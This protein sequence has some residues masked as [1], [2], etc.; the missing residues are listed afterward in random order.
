[1]KLIQKVLVKLRSDVEFNGVVTCCYCLDIPVDVF[2]ALHA[3][4]VVDKHHREQVNEDSYASNRK[5]LH[6]SA[7]NCRL[8]HYATSLN[9]NL[10]IISTLR[11]LFN[12]FSISSTR[13][14]KTL[15]I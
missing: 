6:R 10:S 7:H 4:N 3:V 12:L 9:E 13:V 1:M 5:T 14:D 8:R 15:S 2:A 11:C